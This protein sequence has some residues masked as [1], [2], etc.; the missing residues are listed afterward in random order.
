[1]SEH[2]LSNLDA[3]R[4]LVTSEIERIDKA[5]EDLRGQ[6]DLLA[7][8]LT[9][10]RGM[11]ALYRISTSMNQ[12]HI[13]NSDDVIADAVF[14]LL[15]ERS[16]MRRAEIVDWLAMNSGIVVTSKRIEAVLCERSDRF[17]SN[18]RGWWMAKRPAKSEPEASALDG[19]REGKRG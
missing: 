5:V 4:G 9:D 17:R 15:R 6:R 3:A 16:R 14:D 8:L 18:S 2:E 10:E 12:R 13:L 1:M 7:S 19:A 11:R